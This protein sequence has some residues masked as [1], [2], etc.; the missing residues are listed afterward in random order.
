MTYI[1]VIRRLK[2]NLRVKSET[3]SLH[4]YL[5]AFLG[6]R[7]FAFPVLRMRFQLHIADSSWFPRIHA[8]ALQQL[9]P[10]CYYST[11]KTQYLES[12]VFILDTCTINHLICNFI[13]V[14]CNE[15]LLRPIESRVSRR[16]FY[17]SK[18][19]DGLWDP[20]IIRLTF[21][22]RNLVFKFQHT[23][24]VKCEL[25]RNQKRQHYEIN[26][27]LER[28]KRRVCSMFKKFSTYIC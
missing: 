22:H 17:Y 16:S 11:R 25:Y 12:P 1:Y 9:R 2:V 27:I 15:T 4:E 7:A 18:H 14:V 3:K 26:G 24:Y 6:A 23:L 21:Q 20:L 19:P 8:K 13:S 10:C 5:S 28:N